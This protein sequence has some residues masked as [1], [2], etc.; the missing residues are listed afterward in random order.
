MNL[1]PA[2]TVK[3]P[4]SFQFSPDVK[5]L[6]D[7]PVEEGS[8]HVSQNPFVMGVNSGVGSPFAVWIATRS[9]TNDEKR[10]RL[11]ILIKGWTSRVP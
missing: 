5:S 11:G 6:I 9:Y 2:A 3:R 1:V 4:T 7:P 8:L 10:K